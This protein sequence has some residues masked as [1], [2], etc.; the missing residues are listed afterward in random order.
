MLAEDGHL[1]DNMTYIEVE[2]FV[3]FRGHSTALA[4]LRALS[5]LEK[6]MQYFIACKLLAYRV[7]FIPGGTKHLIARNK[8]VRVLPKIS[9]RGRTGSVPSRA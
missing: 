5:G 6:Q 4:G 3:S 1:L 9:W 2:S 7:L 8:Y